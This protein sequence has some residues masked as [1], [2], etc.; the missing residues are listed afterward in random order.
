L[1]CAPLFILT[2]NIELCRVLGSGIKAC[3]GAVAKFARAIL[4][5]GFDFKALSDRML[6]EKNITCFLFLLFF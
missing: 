6:S 1:T 5:G 3:P 2:C 4:A